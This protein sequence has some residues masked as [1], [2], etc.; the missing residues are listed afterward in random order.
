MKI[1]PAVYYIIAA[2]VLFFTAYSDAATLSLRVTSPAAGSTITGAFDLTGTA[3]FTGT[4][5]PLD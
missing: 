3:T 1:K 2:F 4:G 5:S